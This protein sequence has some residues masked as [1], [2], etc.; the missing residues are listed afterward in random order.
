MVVAAGV[1]QSVMAL[2]NLGF[3]ALFIC[4]DIHYVTDYPPSEDP[5]ENLPLMLE[6]V[7]TG[8]LS[9]NGLVFVFSTPCIM[10]QLPPSY[11]HKET[12]T[13]GMDCG[14]TLPFLPN[15]SQLV[16]LLLLNLI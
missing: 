12:D 4:G 14:F 13:M 7:E 10:C 11:V 2:N 15:F 5:W 3:L 8:F 6:V 9:G 1:G 16:Q